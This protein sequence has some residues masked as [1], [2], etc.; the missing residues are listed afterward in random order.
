MV[1]HFTQDEARSRLSG[2]LWTY[3][4]GELRKTDTAVWMRKR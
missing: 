4:G 3:V 2:T 1:G